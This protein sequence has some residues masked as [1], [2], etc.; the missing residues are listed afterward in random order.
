MGRLLLALIFACSFLLRPIQ[1][2]ISTLW[3]RIVESDKPVFTL[4]FGGAAFLA[5]T[6]QKIAENLS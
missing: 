4:L 1:R 5:E 6:I 2:P 3:A